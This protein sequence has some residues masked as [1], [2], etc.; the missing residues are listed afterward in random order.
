MAMRTGF[1]E[2]IIFGFLTVIPLYALAFFA[3]HPSPNELLVASSVFLLASVF[4]DIDSP[5]SFIRRGF[6]TLLATLL[7]LLALSLAFYFR[8]PLA[9]LCPSPDPACYWASLIATL[10]L[11]FILVKFIDL[12]I[13]GHR[14]PLHTLTAAFLFAAFCLA[15]SLSFLV[16]LFAF[17]GYIAHLLLDFLGPRI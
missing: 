1:K 2:H 12:L 13:P 3:L 16:G 6:R 17:C 15:F 11:P 10:I 5:L 4:P 9:R 14:G 8:N 7:F